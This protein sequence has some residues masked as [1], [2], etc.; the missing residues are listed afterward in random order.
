MQ[1]DNKQASK[2]HND[3]TQKK[4]KPFNTYARFS[5]IVIQMVAIIGIG[6][7]IGYKLDEAYPN[8]HNLYTLAGSL[9]SVII[10]IVYIIRRIIAASKDD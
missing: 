10:S 1:Q 2:N 7:F 4:D 5:G 9:S 6:T 3:Q 8:E